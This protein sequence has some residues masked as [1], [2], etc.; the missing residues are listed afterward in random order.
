MSTPMRLLAAMLPLVLAA[1]ATTGGAPRAAA[2]DAS[3]R[4][5]VDATPAEGIAPTPRRVSPYAPA[6][7]DLSKRGD[8]VAGGLFRPG[9]ADT[10]PDE[11]PD[12][13]LIPEPEVRD[14][15][16]A[17]SGNRD[18]A[19]LGQKYRVLDDHEGY[20]EEGGASY[21]GKKFHGR[22]TSSGEVYDMYAF[23]AAHKS[24][25]LPSFA[26]VTN[27]DN[28]KSVVV[29]VND[30]GPFH[31]GR[32]IDLSYAAAV[33]LGYRE[34]GT[35]RVRVE[36]LSADG[37]AVASAAPV[38]AATA[39]DKLVQ[40]L[41]E[42]KPVADT[43]NRFDMHQDGRTMGADEFDA[44]MRARQIRVATGKPTPVAANAAP[45]PAVVAPV[46]VAAAP[47]TT[48]A[49][50]SPAAAGI[51]LQVASFSNQ[52]NAE[53]ALSLLRGAAIAQAQLQD[54]DING[55][56][57][58]RLRIGPVSEAA[59]PELAARIVGLG[60]GQPQRIRN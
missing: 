4:K 50:S 56:K 16:R 23:S 36:A 53:Q 17:R 31:K 9:V 15:P 6:Q 32:I 49:A 12:V 35:A 29:R 47:V 51:T 59:T 46:A 3:T 13:D 33:K 30:R 37:V 58:W 25:P 45:A 43:G 60:F 48:A 21:Y 5:P 39:M 18:Y 44:W 54:A 1:C 26:R 52:R 38:A 14:E 55:R 27:L 7:E 2:P 8:Y 10:V 11:I 19:V 41:P 40:A 34:R 24:L 42:Q 22:R 20:N 28:G 57:V